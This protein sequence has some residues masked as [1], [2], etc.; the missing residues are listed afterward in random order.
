[1]RAAAVYQPYPFD[2]APDDCPV[3]ASTE[4]RSIAYLPNACRHGF[5]AADDFLRCQSVNSGAS[6]V[7]D[8]H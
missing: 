4:I 8:Y 6:H 3:T 2:D 7:A 5:Y 1:M